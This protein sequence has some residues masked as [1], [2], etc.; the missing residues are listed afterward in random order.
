MNFGVRSKLFAISVL[1]ISGFA[2]A[3]GMFLELTLRD[4]Y[5]GRIE[6]ELWHQTRIARDIVEMVPAIG[7]PAEPNALAWRLAESTGSRITIITHHGAVIADSRLADPDLQRVDN[8][9]VRPEILAAQAHGAGVSRR[10]STTL[11]TD[12]LYVAMPY[13]REDGSGVIR[14]AMPLTEVEEAIS[15]MRL[16]VFLAGLVGL[17]VALFMTG[18][19][20]HY[21]SRALREL[22]AHAQRIVRGEDKRRIA[23]MSRDEIG[24]IAGSFNQITDK[25]ERVVSTLGSE[26]DQFAA[27]LESMSEAVLAVNSEGRITLINGAAINLL[28]ASARPLGNALLDT[29][30]NPALRVLVD[31][32]ASGVAGRTELQLGNRLALVRA[33][34]LSTSGGSVVVM[35]DITDLRHLETVRRDFVANVSHELRTPVSVIRANAETLLDGALED[36]QAARRFVEALLRNAER[37]GRIIADLLDIS[38]VEAGELKLRAQPVDLAAA[39]RRAVDAILSTAAHKNVHLQ[40]DLEDDV[41]AL[42]DLQALDQVLLNLLDNAVKYTP[43][44]GHVLVRASMSPALAPGVAPAHARVEVADD[45]PGIP[46]HLRERVFE[47]FYRV[48]PGRS[49]DMGGTGLGLSIVKHLCEVMGGKVGV[50]AG[51]PRGSVFWFTLPLVHDAVRPESPGASLTA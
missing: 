21:A 40:V 27:I 50:D 38:R 31:K 13:S 51:A 22:V 48:D 44:G 49:R 25:L 15:K 24:G 19:A 7:P 37:L 42:A 30:Q 36:P 35:H 11:Q 41:Y 20:S 47:R 28:G 14:L 17:G 45:G 4:W 3:S 6:A 33:T 16:L 23:V 34:P 12:M 8:H 39:A 10:F 46:A 29:V 5:E 26:R 1:L 9:R 2:A 32:A 43:S 18:L